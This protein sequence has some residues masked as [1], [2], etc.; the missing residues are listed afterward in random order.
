M[1]FGSCDPIQDSLLAAGVDQ[2]TLYGF[3]KGADLRGNATNPAR[4]L[5]Q[6]L[7]HSYT[8]GAGES[9]N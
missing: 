1:T 3:R 9:I 6:Q 4:I 7:H 5:Y 8:G 2:I